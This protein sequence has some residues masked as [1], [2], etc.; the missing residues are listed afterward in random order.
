MIHRLPRI[1]H[2]WLRALVARDRAERDLDD[3]LRF[4][5]E[6]RQRRMM[7]EG[8]TSGEALR[9]AH[10]EAVLFGVTPTDLPT[11]AAAATIFAAAAT[12]ASLLP[13]LRAARINPMQALRVE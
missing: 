2:Q 9:R 7:E 3:E 4:F 8:L 12:M 1:V 11:F 5:V 6:E 13:A 10:L